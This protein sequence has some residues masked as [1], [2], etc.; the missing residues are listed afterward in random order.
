M[1]LNLATLY[2]TGTKVPESGLYSC[3]SCACW[4]C[5]RA[6]TFRKGG[7]FT[8]CAGC[9]KSAKWRLKQATTGKS[10]S[11]RGFLDFFS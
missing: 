3:H 1:G 2:K 6:K 8:P 4:M 9:K 11:R 5:T 10:A 7:R